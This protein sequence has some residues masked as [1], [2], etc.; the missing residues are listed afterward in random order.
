[1][2][3][4]TW[5]KGLFNKASKTKM[6]PIIGNA[7]TLQQEGDL[8]TENT[9]TILPGAEL[10]QAGADT[11]GV[12]VDNTLQVAPASLLVGGTVAL[13]AA[14]AGSQVMPQ[15]TGEVSE[16]DATLSRVKALLLVADHAVTDVWDD[17]VAFV[18]KAI[19]TEEELADK[20]ETVLLVA[21][22]DVSDVL[23]DAFAFAKKY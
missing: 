2:K 13:A 6:E 16:L 8:S 14:P 19:K 22:H 4:L 17:A 15:P 12:G 7:I 5:L 11:S 1:M 20:L 10:T 23:K 18:K 21:G 9:S 3:F